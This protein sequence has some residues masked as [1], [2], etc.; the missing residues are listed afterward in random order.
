MLKNIEIKYFKGLK[1]VELRDCGKVN[2]I[3]GKNNSGKSSLLH[4]IDFAGLA[5]DVRTW[6]QFQP[7]IKIKDLFSRVGN[8]Q[9][10]L[11][12]EDK[13]EI[14][15]KSSDLYA[16]EF[17]PTPDDAQRFKSI[18]IFPD[19]GMGTI[20][21]QHRKPL[22][23]VNQIEERNFSAINSLDI[24][25]AIKF[26]ATRN[27]R[28]LTRESYNSIIQEILNYF[29]EVKQVSS[30]RT[31]DD[32]ATLTY[33]ERSKILDILYAGTGLKHFIDVLLKTI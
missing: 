4:A 32:I 2:A 1:S 5:L 6:N 22:F 30:N 12:Y 13:R 28:N 18:L 7:K 17:Y 23:V 8:F 31:E 29:P 24:L 9:I 20:V 19:P 27:L 15:I 14:K 26:Y 25:Y 3:I 10:N 11:T 16:P 21:R 33:K